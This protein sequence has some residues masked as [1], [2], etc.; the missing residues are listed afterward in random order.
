VWCRISDVMKRSRVLIAGAIA[1]FGAVAAS[2]ALAHSNPAPPAIATVGRLRV[3]YPSSLHHR[4]FSSCSYAVTGVRGAACVRGVVL[5]TYPLKANPELG[6][7]GAS[8]QRN[9]VLFELYRSPTQQPF[10]SRTLPPPA[11]LAD[12]HAVERGT[13]GAGEQRELFFRARGVNYWAIAWVGEHANKSDRED[14]TGVIGSIQ[15]VK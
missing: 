2:N 11:S 3:V 4:Y 1:V 12:F 5:A 9:G 14:L 6:G 13:R 10:A 8:F 7:A 15:L